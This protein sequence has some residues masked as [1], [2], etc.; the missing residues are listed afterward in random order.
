MSI[1]TKVTTDGRFAVDFD[2]DSQFVKAASILLEP[3]ELAQALSADEGERFLHDYAEEH[4]LSLDEAIRE[5]NA[6][7][8]WAKIRAL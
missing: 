3:D 5:V 7:G 4:N 2:M 8:S 6:G 1:E